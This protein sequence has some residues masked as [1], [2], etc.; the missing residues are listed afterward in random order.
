MK[1]KCFVVAI[2]FSCAFFISC[3]PTLQGENPLEGNWSIASSSPEEKYS[4]AKTKDFSPI[5]YEDITALDKRYPHKA[6]TVWL[7]KNF[8]VPQS[9]RG[10]ALAIY[11][12]KSRMANEM[13]MNGHLIGK[14]GRFPP[15][16][17][18]EWIKSGY[19][20]LQNSILHNEKENT[21]LIKL[22][23]D[24]DLGLWN[25]RLAE[26]D[27]AR[28]VFEYNEFVNRTV[29]EVMSFLMIV[30][31]VYYSIMFRY[32]PKAKENLYFA[33]LSFGFAIYFFNFYASRIPE[34]VNLGMTNI[35]FQ[36]ILAAN[37]YLLLF[38]IVSFFREF[39]GRKANR[40]E[41]ITLAVLTIIPIAI[42][43]LVPK[44][45]AELR[46]IDEKVVFVIGILGSYLLFIIVNSIIHKHPYGWIMLIAFITPFLSI[47]YDVIVHE[48]LRYTGSLYIMG[49]GIP[50][51]ILMILFVLARN[52][53][54]MYSDIEELNIH[55]E[56]KVHERTSQLSLAKD[57][58]QAANEELSAINES[59]TNTNRALEDAKSIAD[60]DMRM[61]VN[62]Q[63]SL[64]PSPPNV[65]EWSASCLYKPMSGVSGDLYDFFE[66]DDRLIGAAIFDVS[67]HGIASGLITMI[68]K[69]IV[70]NKDL[71]AQIS[72]VDNYLTG[73]ILKFQ[74]NLVEYVNAGHPDLFCRKSHTGKVY[75]VTLK[76]HDFKGSFLGIEKFKLPYKALAFRVEEGDALLIFTDCF[77]ESRN[78]KDEEYGI[79]RIL[80]SFRR[81]PLDS[82]DEMITFM[83]K[84]FY[85]FTGT[86]IL[87]DDLTVV[88][89]KRLI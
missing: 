82:P 80:D 10:K 8:T 72:N 21:L 37:Q 44:S 45:F 15:N 3:T 27:S 55:L 18:N 42:L 63:S 6:V 31:G 2:V 46:P 36:K 47:L 48:W 50:V 59:L 57:E 69:E 70:F 58:I 43:I 1:L 28:G 78:A 84:E 23:G 14:E 66:R 79:D 65:S 51:F 29:N 25:L 53:M 39:L 12:E 60:R 62:L 40:I 35:T 24:G 52:Y 73:I 71:I 67:G 76:D 20:P 22:Y 75:P 5:P 89:I 54:A 81:A 34:F 38:S 11:T 33:L 56:K 86:D 4:D 13:Y 7:K 87:S 30:F 85:E 83:M 74:N 68:A 17:F 16:D 9:L 49:F 19:Y 41:K 64:L 61:A 77:N 88:I 32:R 26:N